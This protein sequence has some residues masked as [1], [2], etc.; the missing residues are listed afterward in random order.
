MPRPRHGRERWW[1]SAWRRL[2]KLEH[3]ELSWLLVG[4][5]ACV[6]VWIFLSL[7]S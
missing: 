5:G 2:R 7:S 6:M 3:R 4:L 1:T